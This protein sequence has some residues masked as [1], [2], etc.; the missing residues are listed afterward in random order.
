MLFNN[1][2]GTYFDFDA[3][4]IESMAREAAALGAEL[5][6]L[7]DGWF[8]HRNDDTSSL[9]DWTDNEEKTG[10]GLAALAERVRAQGLAFGVWMEPEMISEDSDLYRAH[11]NFAMK[12]RGGS[13]SAGATSSCSTSRTSACRTLSC[14]PS[15]TSF[16]AAAR[17]M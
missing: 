15:P 16:R 17:R 2:E 3:E 7:D 4:K 14:A 12:I 13:R 5:F 8:G 6:V 11:P 10:G 9:G 1:W